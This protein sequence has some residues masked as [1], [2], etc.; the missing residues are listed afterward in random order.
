[1]QVPTRHV[2]SL[3]ADNNI[4]AVGIASKIGHAEAVHVL[5]A[6]G[7]DVNAK[8]IV[9]SDGGLLLEV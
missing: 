3:Q 8:G 6:A 2:R 1:M 7:A 4:T 9:S 5:V